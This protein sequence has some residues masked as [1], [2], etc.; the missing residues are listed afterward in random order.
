MDNTP[1]APFDGQTANEEAQPESLTLDKLLAVTDKF[2]AEQ[3]D[4]DK[5]L[6]KALYANGFRVLV[7]GSRSDLP[8]AILPASFARAHEAVLEEA[9][10]ER[11]APRPSLFLKRNIFDPGCMS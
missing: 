11:G 6:I 10:A 4:L 9:R 5:K 2:A 7:G 8:A 3:F 1:P